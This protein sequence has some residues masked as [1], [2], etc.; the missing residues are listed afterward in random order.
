MRIGIFFATGFTQ[1]NRATEGSGLWALREQLRGVVPDDSALFIETWDG[2]AEHHADRII[3]ANPQLIVTVSYSWGNA[4]ALP[5]F[6]RRIVQNGRMVTMACLIDP[7][8]CTVPIAL[9][10]LCP[11]DRPF[12]LPFGIGSYA[13]WRTLNKPN[14]IMP[15]G[16]EV[17]SKDAQWI[18]SA[19]FGTARAFARY[20]PRGVR[21]E[22]P[23]VTH[24]NIDNDPRVHAD[25]CALVSGLGR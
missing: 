24:A 7:V 8:P 22:D 2:P 10:A 15:W 25:I 4:V 20:Q 14:W 1:P 9:S 16:R 12:D 17:R 6:C 11:T 23:T 13:T 3:R 21:A 18:G 19:C 5:K